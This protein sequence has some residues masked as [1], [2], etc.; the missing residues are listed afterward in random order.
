MD[1][2]AV[3][4]MQM[5]DRIER[6]KELKRRREEELELMQCKICLTEIDIQFT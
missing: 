6:E 4:M 5:N 1:R 2:D 3:E